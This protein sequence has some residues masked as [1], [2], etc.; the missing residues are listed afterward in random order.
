MKAF[1]LP[2]LNEVEG[3]RERRRISNKKKYLP[4]RVGESSYA[5]ITFSSTDSPTNIP[6]VPNPQPQY[7]PLDGGYFFTQYTHG[8][9]GRIQTH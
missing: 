2:V 6:V 4:P 7:Y 5:R 1:L 9:E 3:K 8:K